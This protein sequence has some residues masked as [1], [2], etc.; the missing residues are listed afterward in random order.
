MAK[1]GEDYP[2]QNWGGNPLM[3]DQTHVNTYGNSIG[4]GATAN[5][6]IASLEC[7]YMFA[8]HIFAELRLFYRQ[9]ESSD[10]ARNETI[11]YITAGIR[12]NLPKWRME[13]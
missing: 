1:S 3:P 11:T 13:F 7:S 5:I 8:Q 9:K 6:T 12:A 2:G 10:P 4:Q